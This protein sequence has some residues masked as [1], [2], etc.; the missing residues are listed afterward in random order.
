LTSANQ[1]ALGGNRF[2]RGTVELTTPTPTPKELGLKAHFFV[3]G[4]VLDTSDE[5]QIGTDTIAQDGELRLSS[6]IGVTWAS[7]FGPIRL[8]F[9]EPILKQSYDKIQHIHFSFGTQF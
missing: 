7:P 1:D 8:D 5:K 9:A 3:D 4:G 6:G 2:A